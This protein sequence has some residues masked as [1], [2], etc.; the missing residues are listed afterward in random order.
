LK[1]SSNYYKY[2]RIININQYDG[3][4]ILKI[5]K[6]CKKYYVILKLLSQSEFELGI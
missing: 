6:N 1:I 4:N 2:Y 5:V 3:T